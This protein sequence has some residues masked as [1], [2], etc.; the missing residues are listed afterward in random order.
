LMI[1]VLRSYV[2]ARKFRLHDF[3]I[4]PDHRTICIC[5]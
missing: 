4:M 1:G 3:V 5:C 2:T